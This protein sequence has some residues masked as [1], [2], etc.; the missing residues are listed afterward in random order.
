MLTNCLLNY[1]TFAIVIISKTARLCYLTIS[2][3][4]T[5]FIYRAHLK[6]LKS[7]KVLHRVRKTK[8]SRR[9]YKQ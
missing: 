2:Y 4:V 9:V 5:M 3:N 6:Q 1:V 8:T 7:T